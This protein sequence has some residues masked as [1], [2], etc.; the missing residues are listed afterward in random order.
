ME[1]ANKNWQAR[2][3]ELRAN[4]TTGKLIGLVVLQKSSVADGN[5]HATFPI[6]IPR[7]HDN[8]V[9]DWFFVTDIW[10]EWHPD[11]R[12]WM[13]RLQKYS[14]ERHGYWARPDQ[15]PPPLN[16]RNF[17]SRV[18]QLECA[19]C[20][21]QSPRMFTRCWL[22]RNPDCPDFWTYQGQRVRPED[23]DLSDLYLQ[24][25]WSP[26]GVQQPEV[27]LVPDFMPQY[28]ESYADKMGQ[29]FDLV[30]FN[31][32]TDFMWN[33]FVC[34]RCGMCN[35]RINWSRWCCF[36]RQCDW[37]LA[38]PPPQ[39]SVADIAQ[40][41]LPASDFTRLPYYQ[42][43]EESHELFT[44]F[45]YRFMDGCEVAYWMPKPGTNGQEGGSDHWYRE[46]LDLANTDQIIL[47][48]A[49]TR[50]HGAPGVYSISKQRNSADMDQIHG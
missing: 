7:D 8:W 4:L 43:T 28:Q 1:Q 19:V 47:R 36:S 34:P 21:Q 44:I 31:Q 24:E 42:G 35:N 6:A 18:E 23:L 3:R 29:D 38:G 10:P 13:F 30:T 14:L 33:S 25:R 39:L 45:N 41:S 16:Q 26:A 17:T 46:G 12:V 50:G 20:R 37:T 5:G 15:P 40:G 49:V 9:V 11:G 22:C 27:P 32:L 2:L 48:R